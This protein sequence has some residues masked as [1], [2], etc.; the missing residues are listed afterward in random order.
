[1]RS[2][3]MQFSFAIIIFICWSTLSTADDIEILKFPDFVNEF[4]PYLCKNEII[5]FNFAP[6]ITSI[7][8]DF[9]SSS[10]ITCLNF[11]STYIENIQKGA[12]NKLPN[13]TQLILSYNNIKRENLFN[14]GSHEN[15][16]ILF[17]NSASSNNYNDYNSYIL[18]IFGEYP[19][20]EILSIRKNYMNDLRT[21][22]NKT[23]FPKLK[24]LDLSYNKIKDTNFIKLLPNSLYF[25]DL[26]D[27]SL[28]SLAFD[29]ERVNLLA[30]NVDNNNLKYVN[31]NYSRDNLHNQYNQYIEYPMHY[32]NP[33]DSRYNSQQDNS[34]N[35]GLVMTG[36]KNLHYLSISN[37]EID[38]IES[39]AFEDTKKLVYLNL[40]RNQINYL[41]SEIFDKL[42]FL[43]SLDLSF[44]KFEGVPQISKET[45]ISNLFL[46]DNNITNIIANAFV[47]MPKLTKLSLG[48]N[49]IDEI[50]VKAFAHLSFLEILDLSRNN[51]SFLP[52]TLSESLTSLKYLNLNYN[53]FTLLESLSL[54]TLPALIEVHLA[55]NRLKYLNVSYLKNLPQNLTIHLEYCVRSNIMQFSF[56]IIIFICW[57]TLSTADDIEILKFPD[58]VNEFGPYLCKNEII[59]FNFAPKI[60][61][62]SQDFISS[63]WITCLNFTSTYI[64]NIQKG[65]FNKLP[66]LTQLI[67]SYNIRWENLFNFGS[68][69]NLKIL[70]LNSASSNN[71]NN[72]YNSY[73]LDISGEYPNLEILSIRKSYMV[74]LRTPTNKTPFPKLKI[75]DLSYNKI[76]DTNFIKLLPNSLYFLDLHDN[77]LISLA[78][79]EE[80]VNLLALNLDNNNLKYVKNNNYSR[81]HLHNQY[82]RHGY[83]TQYN[84]PYDSRYNSQQDNSR[85]YGLV[86]TGL[87]NL[88]YLSI[89]NNEIDSIESNAFEDT[90]KL[91]YLNLSRN[92]INYLP[93]EIF[94]KLLF[95]RSLDLSFNKLEGVPQISK[96]TIISNLFLNDNNMT[97][98][99][100]NAFV[101][102]PK[103][104]KLLLAGNRIDKIHVKAFAHLSL[105]EILDL[106]RNSLSFLPETLSESLTSLKY[107]NLNNNKFTLL[108]S[109][110]LNTLPA[111][112]EVHLAMNRLKYL[113]ISYLKNLPQNLTIHLE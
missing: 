41:P 45:I 80:Q 98:I 65:A 15:L 24:I 110:S 100:A 70:F 22:T 112:I 2:N 83:Q 9:I 79:N 103:L 107:L 94:D 36:L 10:W 77:S 38:S 89:S 108:E 75:L 86:M 37:N 25:L 27:N 91:V 58:F 92:Q 71:Y 59:S 76:K 69:E 67:L 23:P 68:H 26:H 17:L 3:I 34:R 104:T 56:A 42:L 106:S 66:N 81:N 40:S 12:F 21:L 60:T 55:M 90:K 4:G 32:Y 85:N 62:I 73:I 47:Q 51:L 16:K 29:E 53:K 113:N 1:M 105:L 48:G 57:S 20:L 31:N 109:L 11:T 101:Q 96:E 33:Y 111:L 39:N 52:E 63:S 35:F 54:N 18:D 102:M 13:L 44:N 82:C 88:H 43:R 74:D 95:L 93:S 78:F 8:Q 6:K 46:N 87:K 28:T 14:F 84:N 5:S 61:S 7:S 49:G 19:N 97:N 64:E 50:H 30:L 72:Y 99:I